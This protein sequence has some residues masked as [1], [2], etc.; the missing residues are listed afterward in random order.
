MENAEKKLDK[1]TF[2]IFVNSVLIIMLQ[3]T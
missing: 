1:I 3:R 2:D